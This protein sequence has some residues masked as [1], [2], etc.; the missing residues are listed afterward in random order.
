M[1]AKETKETNIE[2]KISD[3]KDLSCKIGGAITALEPYEAN[4]VGCLRAMY[5][6]DI[7]NNGEGASNTLILVTD[8]VKYV[9]YEK[10]NAEGEQQKFQELRDQKCRLVPMGELEPKARITVKV[11]GIY[12]VSQ[13]GCFQIRHE[14][15]DDVPLYMKTPLGRGWVGD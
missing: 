3:A 4:N 1:K 14:G 12:P 6:V 13:Y 5:V 9:E 11:W 8:G 10:K 15:H 2:A 7:E